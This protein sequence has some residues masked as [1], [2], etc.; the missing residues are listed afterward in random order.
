MSSAL[1]LGATG[2]VG[3]QILKE[4][5][6][7]PAVSRVTSIGRREAVYDGP[8]KNKLV[9]QVVDFDNLEPHRDVLK[10]H[11]S[12]YITLGTTRAQA[13]SAAAFTKVDQEIPLQCVRLALEPSKNQ[14]VLYCSSA[15]ANKSSMFLYPRSKGETEE[16]LTKLAEA[17]GG[18][19]SIFRPAYLRT[20][21]PRP[22]QRTMEAF[23]G[24]FIIPT[25]ES[26]GF[27]W[28]NPV[29]DVA[30]AMVKVGISGANQSA[31]YDSPTIAQLARDV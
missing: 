22:E 30:K 20:V 27:K 11:D 23:F 13:G 10:G 9:Q 4:L 7:C 12:I 29:T 2:A 24:K 28:S 14:H 17:A 3:E 1:I 21:K 25:I 19:T 16:E 5:L 8:G 6:A 15:G 26:V 31:I 18:R